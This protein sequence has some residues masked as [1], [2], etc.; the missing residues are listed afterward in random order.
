MRA[1]SLKTS[2]RLQRVHALLQ[3]GAEYSTRDITTKCDVYAVS[4]VIAELRANG[5]HIDCRHEKG[6]YYYRLVK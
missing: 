6:V 3:D 2:K 4:A 5:L 1:A